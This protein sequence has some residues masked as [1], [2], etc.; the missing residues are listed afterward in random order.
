MIVAGWSMAEMVASIEVPE[1]E[2]AASD[3]ALSM[4]ELEAIASERRRAQA[5][6]AAQARQQ[7]Q[8]DARARAAAEQEARKKAEEEAQARAEAERLRRNPAR[9]W[10]QIATGANASALAFDCRRFTRQYPTVFRG[11]SC[12][13]APWNRTRRLL[14]GPFRTQ[15]AARDWLA[16]FSRAGGNGFV[17][18]SEAGEEVAAAGGR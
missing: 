10:V 3:G 9:I 17:W 14:V 12:S 11:Q 6:A 15:N 5:A 2:R 16:Q 1:A 4:Q 18:N 7:A 13:T 8:T